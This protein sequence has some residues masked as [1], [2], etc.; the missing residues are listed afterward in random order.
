MMDTE[1]EKIIAVLHDVI[2]DTETT[3]VKKEV[4]YYT[5]VF[6]DKNYNLCLH[7]GQALKL[8]T[9]K[10]Q[11]YE[12]YINIIA[13]SKNKLATKVKIADI[14]CNLLDNPSESQ[15]KKYNKAMKIL[16]TTI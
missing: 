9:H 5:L 4:P 16:L 10:E 14:T 3:L 2:E 6:K 7:S 1:E 12:D 8:L 11:S 13:Y 15:K